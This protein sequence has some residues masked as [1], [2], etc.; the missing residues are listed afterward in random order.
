[1]G[2]FLT[3]AWRAACGKAVPAVRAK[4][5]APSHARVESAVKA[6][7]NEERE[8]LLATDAE[9]SMAMHAVAGRLPAN[10]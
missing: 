7:V 9:L 3:R 1:M 8:A 2:N 5:A 4:R 10:G 6:V